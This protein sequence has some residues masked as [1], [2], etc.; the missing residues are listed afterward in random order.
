[1][2]KLKL[3]VPTEESQITD[4]EFSELYIQLGDNSIG[5]KFL[6][7]EYSMKSSEVNETLIE[8]NMSKLS[9]EHD[10]NNAE[11]GY[12]KEDI[13]PELL[14]KA[15]SIEVYLFME[16]FD[17]NDEVPSPTSLE[18]FSVDADGNENKIN[19]EVILG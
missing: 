3:R 10:I 13:T 5:M 12:A 16:P 1:M 11:L 17:P 19:T 6:E 2:L 14:E 7:L 18:L 8:V 4:V 15:D 9:D